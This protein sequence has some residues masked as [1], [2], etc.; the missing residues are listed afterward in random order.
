MPK[1]TDFGLAKSLGADIGL[2][3]TD[4][5]IGSPSYMAP[6]QAGGTG[7]PDRPGDRRLFARRDPVRALDRPASVPRSHRSRHAR[8]GPLG[9][10]GAA[11]A[12]P[13]GVAGR[14]RDDRLEVPG[15]RSRP[16]LPQRRRAVGRAA[17]VS[18]WRADPG[19]SG[20]IARSRQ[21]NLA[22]RRPLTAALTILSAASTVLLIIV[23]AKTNVAIS[24]GSSER[25]WRPSIASG[26]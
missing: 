4:S 13:T 23:L 16:A 1:V 3:R 5:I 7:Q 24:P 25:R 19:S 12:D 2:T 21:S 6:E 10:A 8:A 22:R 20:G 17:P 9:R 15:E 11:V 26:G 18:Q 14:P